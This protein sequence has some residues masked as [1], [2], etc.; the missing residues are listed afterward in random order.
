MAKGIEISDDLIAG[1]VPVLKDPDALEALHEC[2]RDNDTLLHLTH[3]ALISG[4][5]VF[6]GYDS[7]I[8]RAADIGAKAYETL[9][10]N[11]GE[12]IPSDFALQIIANREID[13]NFGLHLA[14][15][16]DEERR[17]LI[18]KYPFL[19]QGLY[20]LCLAQLKDPTLAAVYGLGSAALMRAAH[21]E[22]YGMWQFEKQFS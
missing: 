22:I 10:A 7:N 11:V 21:E 16:L 12:P 17:V 20:D 19:A 8:I 15:Q 5:R 6:T 14:E 2:A 13:P 3:T 9:G 4:L 1:L 18:Q